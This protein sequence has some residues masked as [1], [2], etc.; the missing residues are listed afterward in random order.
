ME[1]KFLV[2]VDE[3]GIELIE[4]FQQGKQNN[5]DLCEDMYV[6]NNQFVAVIDG[7]TNIW[8]RVIRGKSPGRFAAEVIK[9]SIEQIENERCTLEELIENINK[10]LQQAYQE[11]GIL[12]EIKHNRTLAPTASLVVYSHYH[13]EIWQIGDCQA[14]IDGKLFINEK[15]L[16]SITANA[17]SLFLE[18]ELKKGKTV[19]DLLVEDSGWDYI[20]PLIQQQYYLQNDPESQYGFEVIDGF[21]VALSKVKK[22]KVPSNVKE[23]VLASDGYPYLKPTLQESED[24]LQDLLKTDPLCFQQYKCTKGLRK[25]NVSFDD[26]LYIR[27][28]V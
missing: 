2:G 25:G 8:D 7:A 1:K 3:V 28:G 11:N 23:M 26:R 15:E 24:S 27:F 18:A 4:L 14:M 12:E 22:I 9:Q 20:K 17:R 10:D 16:D 19:E 21:E 13:Q 5:E 6:F